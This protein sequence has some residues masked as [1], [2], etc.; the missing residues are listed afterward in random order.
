MAQFSTISSMQSNPYASY[1]EQWAKNPFFQHFTKN[2]FFEQF[3]KNP[4]F[5]QFMK[6]PYFEQFMKSPYFEQ[7]AKNPYFQQAAKNPFQNKEGLQNV[8]NIQD[9]QGAQHVNM[10]SIVETHRILT[11][12]LSELAR[13]HLKALNELSQHGAQELQDLTKA[14]GM[15]EVFQILSQGVAKASP[16]VLEHI[17]GVM[18]TILSTASEYNRLLEESLMN[19][20]KAM[21]KF[22]P[23]KTAQR[24]QA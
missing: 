19:T 1:F 11:L 16:I 3:A 20:G 22:T 5:E 10:E 6:N 7:F 15:E 2:P 9:L 17:Q 4:F 23:E 14:R 21:S 12:L 13:L 18:E 8:S 24:K